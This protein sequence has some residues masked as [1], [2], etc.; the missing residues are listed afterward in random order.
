MPYRH[1]SDVYYCSLSAGRV[2]DQRRTAALPTCQSPGHALALAGSVNSVAVAAVEGMVVAMPLVA[3]GEMGKDLRSV[4]MVQVM[5][6]MNKTIGG[7]VP[8]H[9]FVFAERQQKGCLTLEARYMW[10]MAC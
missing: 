7:S 4:T 10:Y 1:R 9:H 5:L 8:R 6:K 2:F 3:R